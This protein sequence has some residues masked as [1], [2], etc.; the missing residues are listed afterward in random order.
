MISAIG[1]ATPGAF[2]PRHSVVMA[3]VSLR[4]RALSL[5]SPFAGPQCSI[6]VSAIAIAA[7]Q[8]GRRLFF[9]V[10]VVMIRRTG[11]FDPCRQKPQI[12]KIGSLDGRAHHVLLLE[13]QTEANAKLSI[14][15]TTP[16][17]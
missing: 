4:P 2:F 8:F 7:T 16:R 12:K 15:S 6:L 3:P 11:F 10:M 1:I 17:N 5:F 14:V 9:G 13:R